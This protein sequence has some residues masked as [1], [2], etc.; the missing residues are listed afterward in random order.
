MKYALSFSLVIL[1][2]NLGL[3]QKYGMAPDSSPRGLEVGEAAP[4]IELSDQSGQ[5]F[6]LNEAL[7]DGP[8][9]LVFYRGNWCPHCSKYL[10]QLSNALPD[11]V[12]TG[13]QLVAVSP[14]AETEINKTREQITGGN[15]T[16]L[17]DVDNQVMNAY[18][19]AYEV[20][21]AYQD[22]LKSKKD[23]SLSAHNNQQSAVLPV[24]ATYIINKD[25]MITYRHFDPD[26]TRRA[27]IRDILDVLSSL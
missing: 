25:G 10:S 3:S 27:D 2:L 8:V 23:L 16:L 12:A 6:K 26:Y 18:D 1:A 5:L 7:S 15:I 11:I 14:E 21:E 17:A 24:A 9:V 19:V 4:Q 22:K 13:G 20:T